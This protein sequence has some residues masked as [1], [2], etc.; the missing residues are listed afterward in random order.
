MHRRFPAWEIL[1]VLVLLLAVPPE[2]SAKWNGIDRSNN[3]ILFLGAP[4]EAESE[5]HRHLRLEDTGGKGETYE[6]HWRARDS[7]L[8]LLRL[9][10]RIQAPGQFFRSN[11]RKSLEQLV[12]SHPLFKRRAITTVESGTTRSMLGSADYLV[13]EAGKD[14]CGTF[15]LYP[16]PDWSNTGDSLDNM[17]LTALYCPV[18]NDVDAPVL[19]SLLAR[20]GI[21]GI[22]EPEADPEEV[23]S[24]RNRIEVLERVVP[25]G[26]MKGLRRIAVQGLDPDTEITF[27]HPRF[28]NGRSIRR[29]LLLAASLYGHVEM[30]VFLL[31]HGATT[32]GSAGGCDLRSDCPQPSRDRQGPARSESFIGG[33]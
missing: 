24:A 21:R 32:A 33:I 29:P 13:F 25:A 5:F 7:R 22:A 15:R 2:A 19:S 14:R 9:R 6:A 1:L 30:T 11:K 3:R 10:L 26:D 16:S 23:P 17:L 20:T 31:D 27:S 4:F 28:A 12:Q 8:P 18:S